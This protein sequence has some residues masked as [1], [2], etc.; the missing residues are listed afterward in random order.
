MRNPEN[1]I[2]S[3]LYKALPKKAQFSI[4][5]I[6]RKKKRKKNLNV[7]SLLCSTSYLTPFKKNLKYYQ[8]KVLPTIHNFTS[9]P[10]LV[11]TYPS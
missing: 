4:K 6:T 11:C 5:V 3:T 2:N 10:C 9:K 1:I 7:S 8:L